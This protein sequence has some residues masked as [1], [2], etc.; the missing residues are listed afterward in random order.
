[1]LLQ[2]F[3]HEFRAHVNVD[4]PKSPRPCVG[5][6]MRDPRSHDHDLAGSRFHRLGIDHEPRTSLQHDEYLFIWVPV[7]ART[8]TGFD[9]DEYQ[10]DPR[11]SIPEA[12]QL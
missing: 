10:A 5:E 4:L 1:M 9:V 3:S 8:F 11:A 2:P 12:L 6:L 7:K